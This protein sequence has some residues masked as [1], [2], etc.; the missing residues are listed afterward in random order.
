MSSGS[1]LPDGIDG[2]I[3]AAGTGIDESSEQPI[4]NDLADL[5]DREL[6]CE[7]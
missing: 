2:G 4:R 6:L 3:P 5:D 7:R 1:A